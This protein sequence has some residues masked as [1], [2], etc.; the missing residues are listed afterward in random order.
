MRTMN[1]PESD[2][3]PIN[4]G[5]PHEITINELAE[6]VI[7]LT[8]SRSRIVYEPLP[9]DDPLQR[10][11]DITKARALLDWEPKMELR[12]GL[13]RTIGYFEKLLLRSPQGRVAAE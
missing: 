12:E 1:A 6:T 8:G 2:G 9:Q 4:T 13:G 7:D 11:P 5:N 3:S 10:R